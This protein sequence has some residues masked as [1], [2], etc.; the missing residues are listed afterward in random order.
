MDI[1]Y[2]G[3]MSWIES[4]NLTVSLEAMVRRQTDCR[5]DI[6]LIFFLSIFFM[7]LIF[8]LFKLSLVTKSDCNYLIVMPFSPL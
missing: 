7:S 2:V 6:Y 4:M 3:T 5:V 1:P 8:L